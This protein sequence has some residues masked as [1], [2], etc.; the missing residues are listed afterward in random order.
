M[1]KI[2]IF[3]FSLFIWSSVSAQNKV[4]AELSNNKKEEFLCD[5][6][7]DVV[8]TLVPQY[9]QNI[10]AITVC[11]SILTFELR[12][13]SEIDFVQK[14]VGRKFYEVY[15][16][17]TKTDIS[18]IVRIWAD[19]GEP[20]FLDFS[21]NWLGMQFLHKPFNQIKKEAK[22]TGRYVIKDFFDTHNN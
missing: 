2:I 18:I 4:F 10:K 14:N 19:N 3:I 11:D 12:R 21:R 16:T 1:K 13:P 8:S 15:L 20:A 9:M 17:N 7:K 6:A 22:T 5:V